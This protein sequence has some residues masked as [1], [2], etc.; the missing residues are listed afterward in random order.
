MVGLAPPVG[1]VDLAPPIGMV[2]QAVTFAKKERNWNFVDKLRRKRY[3]LNKRQSH[4]VTGCETGP[5]EDSS[6]TEGLG[7]RSDEFVDLRT[8]WHTDSVLLSLSTGW[9]R[10]KQITPVCCTSAG[11]SRVLLNHV[12]SSSCTGCT[13]GVHKGGIQGYVNGCE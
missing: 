2:G 13:K 4:F 1:V 11:M 6:C 3:K 7:C 9:H 5:V 8:E 10:S 12:L